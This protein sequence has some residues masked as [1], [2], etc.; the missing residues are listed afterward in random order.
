MNYFLSKLFHFVPVLSS[1]APSLPDGDSFL[2]KI[3]PNIWAFLV[4]FL[5]LVVLI[6]I[7]FVVGYKPVRNIIRKR[8]EHIENQINEAE[9]I[10][11]VSKQEV[12]KVNSTD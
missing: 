9:N 12:C 4:Q 5:A 8:Q 3:I 11:Q 7:F 10:N 6:I 1:D 2:E